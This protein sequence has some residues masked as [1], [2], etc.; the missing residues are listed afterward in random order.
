MKEFEKIF[1][2]VWIIGAILVITCILYWCSTPSE[3]HEDAS[4]RHATAADLSG[5]DD[6][7]SCPMNVVLIHKENGWFGV[8]YS[9][10]Q[11]HITRRPMST[12][13]SCAPFVLEKPRGYD[14]FKKEHQRNQ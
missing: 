13:E 14:E 8:F 11:A 10:G 3:A 9:H 1:K 2:K 7:R 6:H 4:W 5:V 12:G